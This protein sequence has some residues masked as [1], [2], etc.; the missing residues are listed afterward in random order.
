MSVF[1]VQCYIK[2]SI[3]GRMYTQFIEFYVHVTVLHRNKFIR[4]KTNQMH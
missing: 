2:R 4:N 3:S 1:V